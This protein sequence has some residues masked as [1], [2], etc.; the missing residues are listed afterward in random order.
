MA[1]TLRSDDARR[2]D[3]SPESARTRAFERAIGTAEGSVP[4]PCWRMARSAKKR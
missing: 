2:S 3:T 1:T 4:V